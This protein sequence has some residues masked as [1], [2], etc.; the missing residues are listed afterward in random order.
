MILAS[1]QICSAQGEI[2]ANLQ[3]HYR[4]INEAARKGAQLITFPEMSLTGY[5]RKNAQT[6]AFQKDDARLEGLQKLSSEHGIIIIAGAPIKLENELFIGSFILSP[7]QPISIYTKQFLHEGEDEFFSSSFSFNPQL[8]LEEEQLSLAIC[9]DIDHAVHA[10]AACEAGSSIYL[11]SIFFT[12]N[13]IGE[14]HKLLQGY[15][16]KHQ[17]AVLMSNY[18]GEAWGYE[19]GGRS[20]FWNEKGELLGELDSQEEGLLVVE[21]R[22]GIWE[23]K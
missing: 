11:P 19:A 10:N 6:L 7:N 9:A 14:G 12:T 16:Q 2:Q 15:S 3:T 5:E 21:K 8:K 13:G 18:C 4:L 20:A 23:K 1:A 17:L 22:E